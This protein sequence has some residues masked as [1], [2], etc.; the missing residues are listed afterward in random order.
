MYTVRTEYGCCSWLQEI[1]DSHGEATDDKAGVVEE[2]SVKFLRQGT[3][4]HPGDGVTDPN[5][6]NQVT[7]LSFCQ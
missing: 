6:T 5:E 3:Q 4:H 1:T 7:S 2:Q